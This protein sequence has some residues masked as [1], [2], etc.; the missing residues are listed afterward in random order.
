LAVTCL[1]AGG[2]DYEL[3]FTVPKSRRREIEM[4]SREQQ[5]SLARVGEITEGTGLSVLDAAGKA[6]TLNTQGY[7]HFRA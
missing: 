3:C 5:D 4:L 2:D 6:I 1:L 7:D